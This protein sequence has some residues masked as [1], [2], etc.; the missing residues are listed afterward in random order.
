M[1]KGNLDIKKMDIRLYVLPET[2]PAARSPGRPNT[3]AP[4]HSLRAS[5]LCPQS[6]PH[7][8]HSVPTLN[9]GRDSLFYQRPHRPPTL[10][11]S[12]LSWYPTHT[13]FL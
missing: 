5:Q 6:T 1:T 10:K 9:S 2:T 13:H 4:P 8:H 11:T 7:L 12:L 3:H